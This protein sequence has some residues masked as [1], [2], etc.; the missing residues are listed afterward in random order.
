MVSAA[1][2][3]VPVVDPPPTLSSRSASWS[4]AAARTASATSAG[5]VRTDGTE[6][7]HYGSVLADVLGQGPLPVGRDHQDPAR[8]ESRDLRRHVLPSGARTEDDPLAP[9]LVD[10]S[11]HVVTARTRGTAPAANAPISAGTAKA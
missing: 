7:R 3:A 5:D 1:A 2:F 9:G 10:D 8:A 11:R 4:R 6:D